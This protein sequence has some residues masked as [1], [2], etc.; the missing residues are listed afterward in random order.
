MGTYLSYAHLAAGGLRPLAEIAT[1][2]G[3]EVPTHDVL[4]LVLDGEVLDETDPEAAAAILVKAAI[5]AVIARVEGILEAAAAS[6]YLIPLTVVDDFIPG[7]LCDLAWWYLHPPGRPVAEDILARAKQAMTDI[8]RIRDGSR[9]LTAAPAAADTAGGMP[10][11]TAPDSTF[12]DA[13][14]GYLG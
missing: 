12:G 10:D 2:D 14:D 9:L 4:R 11:Y 1:P 8:D 5:D 7:L 13:L 6:R 3:T